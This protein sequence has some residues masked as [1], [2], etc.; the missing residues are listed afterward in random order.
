MEGRLGRPRLV[1]LSA[2]ETGLYDTRNNPE[3]FVGLPATFLQLGAA[4]VVATLWQ[5]DDLATA[6]L[7]AKFYDLHLAEK[8]APPT[9]L[10]QAQAWLREATRNELIAFGKVL[11]PP[12]SMRI[13]WGSWKARS[14]P[15]GGRARPASALHGPVCTTGAEERPAH[16]RRQPMRLRRSRD[17]SRI[18]TIGV[19]SSIRD[20]NDPGVS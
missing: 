2:C 7:M 12:D 19:G 8:L 16:P 6:L 14:P 18:P 4:G 15:C 13:S 20:F 9:A 1:A 17:H 10:K 5:V 3:E 11:A